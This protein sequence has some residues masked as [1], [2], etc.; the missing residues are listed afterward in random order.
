VSYGVI[1]V[2]RPPLDLVATNT[3]ATIG[4][5]SQP[6][7]TLARIGHNVA[8]VDGRILA[9]GGFDPNKPDVFN[10][11]EGRRVSGTGTWQTLAPM[12]TARANSAAA[13][14]GDAV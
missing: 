13:E 2:M 14:L 7:L 5:T 9:V 1:A 6:P 12:P 8:T 4:W 10:S 11:M 3:A